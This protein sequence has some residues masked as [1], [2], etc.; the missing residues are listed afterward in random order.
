MV[1]RVCPHSVVYVADARHV[2][3]V[4]P[5]GSARVHRTTICDGRQRKKALFWRGS[6]GGAGEEASLSAAAIANPLAR[7]A[8]SILCHEG[9][10]R[11]SAVTDIRTFD[12]A[13]FN[14][15][16]IDPDTAKLN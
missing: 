16:S 9:R 4:E 2:E 1:T 3:S 5:D 8:R 13:L 12:P 14:D 10:A 15:A 7:C 11:R 6:P